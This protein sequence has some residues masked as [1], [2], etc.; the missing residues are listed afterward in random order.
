MSDI[1]EADRKKKAERAQAKD[2][3]VT[4]DPQ[5]PNQA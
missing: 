2:A 3:I 1:L 4:P 5:E